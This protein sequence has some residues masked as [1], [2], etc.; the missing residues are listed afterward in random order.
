MVLLE[1]GACDEV[2]VENGGLVAEVGDITEEVP[3]PVRETAGTMI[4]GISE[5]EYGEN[6]VQDD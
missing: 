6:V 2:G 5:W 3:I 4:A 1:V